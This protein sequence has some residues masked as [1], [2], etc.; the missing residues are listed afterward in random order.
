LLTRVATGLPLL[1]PG[2]T[3]TTVTAGNAEYRTT[4]RLNSP[5]D[6]G[7]TKAAFLRWVWYA[8]RRE[9]L[10]LDDADDDYS[11]T[12]RV[13]DALREVVGPELRLT[14]SDQQ[15][16]LPYARV[17]RYGTD[18][19]VQREGVVPKAMSILIA[20][21]VRLTASADDDAA[22]PV[23]TLSKGAFLGVTTLTRQPNPTG[24]QAL[25]EVTVLE[26]ERE[27]LE[28]I[29]ARKPMLLQDLGKLIDERQSRAARAARRDRVG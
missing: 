7:A 18:E 26:I 22:V 15:S 6:D 19:T 25:D 27:H 23:A 28:Q 5:A 3:P 4:V 21:K 20:G 24:A 14:L 11:T 10:H 13:E 16:L 2:T 12:E 1:K 29:V 17:V 9:E 8:A